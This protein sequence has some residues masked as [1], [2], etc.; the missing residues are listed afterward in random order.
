MANVIV[1]GA[2]QGIGYYLVRQLL[3]NGNCVSVF[4]VKTDA[5]EDFKR[6]YPG[7]FCA[8]ICD[9]RDE[10]SV[11][12]RVAESIKHFKSVDIAIHNACC[13]V[14]LPFEEVED[15][16]YQKVLEINVLGAAHLAKAVLPFMKK[17]GKGRVIFTSSGVGVTGFLHISPYASSKGA[18]EALAKCLDLEYRR[19]GIT[20]HLFHPPLTRTKSSAGLPVPQELMASPQKVGSG[21]AKHIAS[22][23]FMI[24]HNWTQS[25]QMRL[26]YLWPMAM[27]RL[28]CKM[29]QRAQNRSQT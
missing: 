21:L 14:L 3:E 23:H 1:T 19:D 17:Q 26:C 18:L 8:Y 20:F 24:C 10:M 9:I 7:R 11:K 6:L 25:L 15:S 29:T 12:Q 4:D 2:N 22:K 16:L 13:C 28:M 27:G 5:L